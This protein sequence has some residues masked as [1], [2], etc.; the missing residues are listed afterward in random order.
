MCGPGLRPGSA[1]QVNPAEKR[2]QAK[3][4]LSRSCEP[5]RANAGKAAEKGGLESGGGATLGRLLKVT[6]E[7]GRAEADDTQAACVP[8]CGLCS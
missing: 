5:E 3:G 1:L 4:K 8:S 2:A 6:G 7:A